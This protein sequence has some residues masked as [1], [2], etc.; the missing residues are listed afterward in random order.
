MCEKVTK[1]QKMK[2]KYCIV[3][4]EGNNFIIVKIKINLNILRTALH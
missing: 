2:V 3:I 1:I 4:K